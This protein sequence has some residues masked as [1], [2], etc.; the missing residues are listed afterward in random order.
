MLSYWG[1]LKTYHKRYLALYLWV[2]GAIYLFYLMNWPTPLSLLLK[3]LG[4]SSW[5]AGMTRASVQ[6]LKGNWQA[7][8]TY[9]P[10]LFV[11]IVLAGIQ[12][13]VLPVLTKQGLKGSS[14]NQRL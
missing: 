14:Y 11:V 3:P 12:V 4:V 8:W 6:L 2:G 10:L 1:T 7:A 13:F 5:S 9:N